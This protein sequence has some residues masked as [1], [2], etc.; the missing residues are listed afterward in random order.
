ML[1]FR[2]QRWKGVS[3][4]TTVGFIGL[5]VMGGPMARNLL[6][7]GFDVVGLNRSQA[8]AESFSR[9]GGRVATDVA[10]LAAESDMVAL[11]LPDSAEVLSVATGDGGVLESLRTGSLVIDFSTI[12]PTTARI[13]AEAAHPLGIG[14][15]DAPVSGGETGAVE[16]SLSIM[17]GGAA[18]HVATAQPL[19]AAVGRSV[20][21][22]GP[23]GAGQV[24][25]AAN[26][27]I[28]GGTI[29]LVAE[30]LVFLEASDIEPRTA[31]KVLA[32]GM[33]GS[34]VL[35]RKAESML[36]RDFEPGFRAALHRKDLRIAIAAVRD[37]GIVAPLT[38]TV[39]WLMDSL[40]AR[41]SGHLDHG[42]LLTVVEDLSGL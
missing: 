9:D 17:V 23:S 20:V 18:E 15:L 32:G 5:G 39:D 30:A 28:V 14:V 26:Q 11:M 34:A 6:K 21:H 42:A 7:A 37:A 1:A 3:V 25:K 19:F 35:D 24:V 8:K 16:G 40:V 10:E 33:A 13:V 29:G 22:V 27:M 41:G 36:R 38:A 31:M 4:V 12:A 2:G